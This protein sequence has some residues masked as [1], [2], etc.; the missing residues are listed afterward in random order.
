MIS[1]ILIDKSG[2]ITTTRIKEVR[3]SEFY[4]KCGFK[5]TNDFDKRHTWSTRIDKTQINVSLYAKNKSKTANFENK[6]EFPPPVDSQLYFGT[7]LLIAHGEQL[8][9]GKIPYMQLTTELWNRIYTKLYGGFENLADTAEMDENEPDLLQ[10]IPKHNLTKTGYLKD[11]F[12]VDDDDCVSDEIS[13]PESDISSLGLSAEQDD[14]P[15]ETVQLKY[16]KKKGKVMPP[17]RNIPILS[18]ELKPDDFV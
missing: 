8:P 10:N 14:A 18:E 6:Y 2:N 7:C 17:I 9:C 11:G 4:K 16:K 1:A 5:N 15:I 13:E 12:V 3:E